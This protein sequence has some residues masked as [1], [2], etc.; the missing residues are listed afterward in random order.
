M[1]DERSLVT[2]DETVQAIQAILPD[3]DK[4]SIERCL[5]TGL[6]R[7]ELLLAAR[8]V[9][10]YGTTFRSIARYIRQGMDLET[11]QE[12]FEIQ[13]A[14]PEANLSIP[15]I[16][17]YLELIKFSTESVEAVLDAIREI[18]RYCKTRLRSRFPAHWLFHRID[19]VFDGDIVLLYHLW[20]DNEKLTIDIILEKQSMAARSQLMGYS[21]TH[22]EEVEED[23][24]NAATSDRREQLVNREYDIVGHYYRPYRHRPE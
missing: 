5:E 24:Q 10:Q 15:K 19:E 7:A 11:I 23:A 16:H 4:A 12:C 14:F 17:Q 18:W 3:A 1:S 13:G 6:T 21:L 8:V 2:L 20:L 9:N 22:P